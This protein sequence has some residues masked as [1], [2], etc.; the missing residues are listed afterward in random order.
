MFFSLKQGIYAA[1]SDLNV[2]L[3]DANRDKYFSISSEVGTILLRILNTEFDY[4][5]G[6]YRA[7]SVPEEENSFDYWIQYF[8]ESEFIEPRETKRDTI[9]FTRSLVSGGLTGYQWDRK[10]RLVS[11]FKISPV[12]I[13]QLL[14]ILMKVNFALKRK[15]IQGVLN[16]LRKLSIKHKSQE[17][18]PSQIEY[19][20]NAL[21]AACA[22]YP[23]K[24]YCLGWATTF[25]L[26]ALKKGWRCNLVIGVQSP[27]F[28]AHAWAE[29]NNHVVNDDKIIQERLVVLLKEPFTDNVP[30]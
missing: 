15:G 14:W 6:M 10:D 4:S 22:L 27:P 21:D 17:V 29:I 25:T 19:L 9:H 18:H 3:L 26:V 30:Y 8:I 11:V 13:V 7:L 12:L 16:M 5:N 2:I 20:S 28:Y 23:K 1:Q 24:I